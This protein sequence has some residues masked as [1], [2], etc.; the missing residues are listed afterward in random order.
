MTN[1]QAAIG[2]AQVENGEK[3]V[4]MRRRNA[5]R[6]NKYLSNVPGIVLPPEEP[7]AKNVYWMYG[8]LVEPK[9]FGMTMP[10]LRKALLEKG[11]DTRT[12][13]IPMHQQPVFKKKDPRFPETRGEYPVANELARKG[14]YLP[15][16]STLK[17]SQIKYVVRMIKEIQE[18]KNI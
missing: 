10:E 1:I 18:L 14:F 12:F 17:K 7:W 16:S 2:L 4:K 15:S 5:M 8:I 9:E 11:I 3:L 13:F 6:Y